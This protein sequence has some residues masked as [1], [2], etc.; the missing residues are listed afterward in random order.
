MRA[1]L[2]VESVTISAYLVLYVFGFLVP[3]VSALPMTHYG[4]EILTACA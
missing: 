1:G 3:T 4:Y 2:V